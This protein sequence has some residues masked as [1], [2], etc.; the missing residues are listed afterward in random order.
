MA[1][2]QDAFDAIVNAHR[3]VR[4][5]IAGI[6]R[7]SEPESVVAALGELNTVLPHHFRVEERPEGF[8]DHLRQR[9]RHAPAEID[10]LVAEHHVLET[11]LAALLGA[12]VHD[13]EWLSRA[14][15]FARLLS[16]HEK[17]EA[18]L[19]ASLG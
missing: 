17:K 2:I 15:D 8:F 14:Q 9:S 4:E 16:E 10:A 3:V 19:G 18:R 11:T 13:A 6:L 12:D 1:R 5:T 7:A